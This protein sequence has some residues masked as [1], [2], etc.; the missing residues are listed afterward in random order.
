VATSAQD[1][2]IEVSNF[3][4]ADRFL[5]GATLAG[6]VNLRREVMFTATLPVGE[7]AALWDAATGDAGVA[8]A[9]T[10][11]GP[12]GSSMLWSFPAVKSSPESWN[13][14]GPGES[15]FTFRRLACGTAGTGNDEAAVTI[16]LP[17]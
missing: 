5:N 2:G 11:A 12:G 16:T 9:V 3:I 14:P 13:T 8:V 1:V 10:F 4:D 6:L 7:H 17:S 15:Y